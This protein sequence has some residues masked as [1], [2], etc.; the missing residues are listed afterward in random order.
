MTELANGD[1]VKVWTDYHEGKYGMWA[2]LY[3]ASGESKGDVTLIGSGYTA[4]SIAPLADGRF[5]VMW[6]INKYKTQRIV[7]SLQD[8][9]P[10]DTAGNDVIYAT[11]NNDVVT[12]TEGDDLL[13]GRGGDDTLVGGIGN[14]TLYGEE[15]ADSLIGGVGADYLDGGEDIDTVSYAASDAGVS[16]DLAAGTGTGGHAEGDILSNIEN[17]IG[18]AY[19]DNITGNDQDNELTG[20]EGDDT[21]GGAGGNDTVIYDGDY[22]DY[23]V[24]QNGDGTVTVAW[25]GTGTNWGTDTLSNIETIKFNDKTIHLDG[26]NN[27]P[28]AVNDTVSAVK[29]TALTIAVADLLA[30]DSDFDG[31]DLSITSVSDPV[32]GTVEIDAEGN[33]VFTPTADFEG[34]A[35]FKYTITDVHGATHEAIV[36][37]DV[38]PVAPPVAIDLD[39]DGLE[40]T[41]LAASMAYMDV[42]GDGSLEHT[43]WV[44]KDD[45]VLA[46]DRN[47]DGTV[48][49]FS[50]ISFAGDHADARTDLEG[51]ALAYDSNHDGMFDSRDDQWSRFGVWQ[52]ANSDGVCQHGEFMSMDSVGVESINLVSDPVAAW[53]GDVWVHG[54]ASATFLDGHSAEVGDIGLGYTEATEPGEMITF[55]EVPREDSWLHSQL[56]DL[57]DAPTDSSSG[58]DTDIHDHGVLHADAITHV[59]VPM[60][61]HVDSHMDAHIDLN[62]HEL[63]QSMAAFHMDD[64]HVDSDPVVDTHMPDVVHVLW[65][66]TPTD[67]VNS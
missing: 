53:N 63:V 28:D 31:D 12:A 34:E 47:H 45:G 14:D 8:P 18:S 39:G 58:F 38:E 48:N 17:V 41:S 7:V 65:D 55:G 50:E 6:R 59:D 25:N 44:G 10:E 49:G 33:V 52:D 51:L 66:E 4:S 19:D 5:V 42:D 22:S 26:T 57:Y 62:P 27:A 11:D 32:N 67:D 13:K 3:D 64:S 9:V 21:L 1:L 15:G 40:F 46:F 20:G 37:V 30:N 29:D 23:T 61:S 56:Q 54:T 16:I 24:T 43:A 35:S 60:D 36:T 2:Q